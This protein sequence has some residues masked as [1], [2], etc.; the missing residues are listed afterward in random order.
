MS[1]RSFT[2][3]LGSLL[4][5][6]FALASTGCSDSDG[7]VGGPATPLPAAP[8]AP[9]APPAAGDNSLIKPTPVAKADAG[10]VPGCAAGP[11][12]SLS[13][14]RLRTN[15]PCQAWLERVRGRIVRAGGA[16]GAVW[17]RHTPSGLALVTGAVHV[18]G[19]GALGPE[20]ANIAE[21]LAPP[22]EDGVLRI[23]LL[24]QDGKTTVRAPGFLLYTPAIPGAEYGNQFV[25]LRPRHDFTVEV[26]DGQRFP[27]DD[28]NEP[29]PDALTM[30]PV[31]V[32][33]PQNDTTA[34][35]TFGSPAPDDVVLY[36]GFPKTGPFAE[37][38]AVGFGRV[39]PDGDAS[40][41]IAGLA[42]AGDDEGVLP[43]D[44]EAEMM[45]E[46]EAVPGMSGGG[47]FDR[48]GKL[49]GI[50][51]RASTSK[52]AKKYVRVVRLAFVTSVIAAARAK[53]GATVKS[54]VAPYL[55]KP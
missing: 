47:V 45:I 54:A 50:M 52:A 13:A 40:A 27:A 32:F 35:P 10:T 11:L 3:A 53:L 23:R 9:P 19:R 29:L 34:S 8:A 14:V 38:G 2:V 30:G 21:R 46:G 6:A 26:M 1:S 39:L 24:S 55:P 37:D 51:V 42:A 28:L 49:A 44:A 33:D 20:G 31:P 22:A 41:A 36:A 5:A 17:T 48:D 7:A 4:V 12:A 18:L 43:Y 25:A 15:D 16:S